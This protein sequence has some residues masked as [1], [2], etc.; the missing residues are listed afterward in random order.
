MTTGTLAVNWAVAQTEDTE[1]QWINVLSFGETAETIA[2]LEPR[3]N[4]SIFGRLQFSKY[5]KDGEEKT[6][7]QM[8]VDDVITAR[9]AGPKVG[10]RP[11]VEKAS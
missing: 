3:T 9:T 1:T 7:L 5:T 11:N 8:I 2:K 6:V 10:R 4:I